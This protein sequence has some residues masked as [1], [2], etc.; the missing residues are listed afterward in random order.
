MGGGGGKSSNDEGEDNLGRNRTRR[1]GVGGWGVRVATIK[2]KITWQGIG[3]EE[4][5]VGVGGEG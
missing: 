3:P 5:G 2:E 1:G 4:G